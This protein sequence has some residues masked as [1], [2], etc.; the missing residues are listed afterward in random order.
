MKRYLKFMIFA[1]IPMCL[2][3]CKCGPSETDLLWEEKLKGYWKPVNEETGEQSASIPFYHFDD[4]AQG[5][6]RYYRYSRT[7]T[8]LWEVR[9]KQLNVYYKKA[10]DGYHIGYDRY[11]SRSLMHI[12]SISD[13]E[14][15]ISQL[16]NNGYQSDYKLVRITPEE[17]YTSTELDD[18]QTEEDNNKPDNNDNTF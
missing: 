10:V 8:L 14:I 3:F 11:N 1:V 18:N 16:Y 6:S 17:F 15:C 12:R 7:D 5:A 9:R 13:N 4:E 2:I